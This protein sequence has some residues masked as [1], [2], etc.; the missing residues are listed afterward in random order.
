MT[1]ETNLVTDRRPTAVL[2]PSSAV[3]DGAVWA[4]KDGRAHRIAVRIGAVGGDLTEIRTGVA[5]GEQVI[6]KPP[7]ALKDG[8]RVRVAK[9][10]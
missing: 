9:G 8:Q 6:V 4:V 2:A 7:E 1:V 5:A 10:R 3:R